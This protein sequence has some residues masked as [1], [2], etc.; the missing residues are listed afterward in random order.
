MPLR[1]IAAVTPIALGMMALGLL[2]AGPAWPA[3]PS[4][5][6]ARSG[7]VVSLDGTWSLAIDPQNLGREQ[8]WSEKPAPGAKDA[9]VPWII[10]DA[11]PGYHGVA[12]YWRDFTPPA[13]PHPAGRYLLRFWAVDY[14]AE[15]WLNGAKVGEHEDGE[16]P[17]ILD[18]TETI[19]PQVVNRLA[20][21]VLNPTDAPIDGITLAT[22]PH[23]NKTNHYGAGASYNHGGIVDSVELLVA[24]AVRVEDLFVRPDAKTGAIR[25]QANVRNAGVKAVAGRIELSVAPAAGGETLAA[26]VVPRELPVGDTLVE[27][28]L[29]VDHPH[30]WDLN[31]PFLYRVTAR[32][33]AAGSSSADESSVRCGFRDF[34]FAGGTFRLNGRRIYLRCSHT[35]NHCPVGLQL[36]HDPD[37]LRRDLL[38]VK[39]MGF[40]AVRFIAGVAT[41]YQLD[42]C[43]EIGL[44]VYEEPYAAWCLADSPKMPDRFDASLLGMVRRDRNHP[45][46]TI[47][48]L[49]NETGDGP[50]FRH[51]VGVLAALRALDDSRLVLLNSGRWDR[52]T[53]ASEAAVAIW[54]GTSIDPCV[55]HNGTPH[56]VQALGVTWAPGQ[57]AFHPGGEG[58][59]SVVRW[60]APAAGKVEVAAHFTGIAASATT[61]VHLL[62]NDR[63]LWDGS[64]NVHGAGNEAKHAVAVAVQKGDTIDAA[65]G[66]GNGHYGGDSTALDVVVKSDDGKTYSA[67]ADFSIRENPSG[68]WS[69][70]QLAPGPAPK[71]ATFTLYREKQVPGQV[72]PPIGSLSNP[73]SPVWE[74]LMNDQHPYQRVP[75]TAAT[76]RTLRTV[77]QGE[78]PLFLSEYGI[79]SGVD[80]VRVVRRYEQLGKADVEDAQFYRTQRDRFLDDW[81]RWQMAQA[82]GRPEEFFAQSVARMGKQRLLG[83]NAIRA[84][85]NV[86][87][88]SLTGTVDQGMSGEG[89]TTTFR[90]LKPGT[91][92][93][94]FDAWAPLR[95]CLFAEP[96]VAYRKTP[97]RLEAL[98]ANEDALA[99]GEYPIRLQVVGPN[100]A[101][102]FERVLTVKIAVSAGRKPGELPFVLPVFSEDV[103]IDGP[104]GKYR[105]L[106][107]FERGAAAAGGEAEFYLADP[108]EMPPVDAEVVIWGEDPELA[109]WLK[110]HGIRTRPFADVPPPARELI[111]ASGKAPARGGAKAFGELARRIARGAAVVF[112]TP[113]LFAEGEAPTRWVPLRQKG[114]LGGIPRWLYLSDDWAKNHPIF[115]GLPAG[116][117]LDYSV[118]QD[119]IPDAVWSG[120]EPPAEAVAGA[121]NVSCGYASGLTA[122]V[123]NLGAGRFTLSSLRIRETLGPNPVAERLLRNM[124]RHAARD[125]AKPSAELP[126]DFEAQL[127]TLGY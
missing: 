59:Y 63:P 85:P 122:S 45:S 93:A 69:Y 96:A 89:L 88:H 8:K 52:N 60:T 32:A 108:A 116:G 31:D 110:E 87:G 121:N 56:V 41:R 124:L 120:Q 94:M 33:T 98:L 40:N 117:L 54:R 34:R 77:G 1:R 58:Q 18:V 24:P 16:S 55:T 25:I 35:G 23:R 67:A 14:R 80:L 106:A 42:L 107:T 79:G 66:F 70:G 62:H 57:L 81:Q 105:F 126:A 113:G 26:S 112:L 22:I 13:N 91:V 49:L 104:P 95:W 20:V 114:T 92:D 109:R 17:F 50:V 51:A 21:R 36:P 37:L 75:H 47:W 27:A 65:V 39:V 73:G 68:V 123:Y 127:K 6:A 5:A 19:K 74:D 43:D 29:Q 48:G 30:R 118:Y 44:M 4:D 102:A 9:R 101:R 64:V 115:D 83:I 100:V 71:P 111:L 86:I 3:A 72:K 125:L 12:W 38:N 7:P 11:F 99:P 15:V 78:M 84:N 46:I 61:D 2:G 97:V 28:Q 90:E 76:I 10:Q 103:V 53:S 82:F 119:L